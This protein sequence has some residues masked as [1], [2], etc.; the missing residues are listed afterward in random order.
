MRKKALSWLLSF[1]MV[2][3]LLTAIPITANAQPPE[4]NCQ[5]VETGIEYSNLDAALTA[6]LDGQ[7]IQLLTDIVYGSI[8]QTNLKGF[9]LDVNDH[10]LTVNSGFDTCVYTQGYDINII[11]NGPIDGVGAFYASS[12]GTGIMGLGASGYGTE[13]NIEV[14]ASIIV[15]GDSCKGI[16]AIEGAAIYLN[17]DVT[18]TGVGAVGAYADSGVY[19][20]L[21]TIDGEIT[22]T[23]YIQVNETTFSGPEQCILP[24]TKT[25]YL[26]YKWLGDSA[27]PQSTVWVKEESYVCEVDGVA[28]TTLDDGLVA[29]AVDWD[30]ITLLAD[31]NY[32]GTLAPNFDLYIDLNEHTLNVVNAS[33]IALRA[34]GRDI[35]ISGDGELNVNGTNYGIYACDGGSAVVTSATATAT[36]GTAVYVGDSS[37]SVTVRGD[38]T[39]LGENGVAVYTNDNAPCTATIQG[40]VYAQNTGGIGAKALSGSQ[41]TVMGR[42]YAETYIVTGSTVKTAGDYSSIDNNYYVF[43][44]GVS[45]VR[46]RQEVCAID[47]TPYLFLEDALADADGGDTITLLANIRF[48]NEI[49]LVDKDLHIDLDTY[50][51][52]VGRTN[53]D[54]A[55]T[56][57]GGMLTIDDTDGGE[58]NIVDGYIGVRVLNDATATVTSISG[59]NGYGIVGEIG[60]SVRV[61]EDISVLSYMG[62]GL[63]L[64]GGAT[65]HVMGDI[66]SLNGISVS[67]QGSAVVIDGDVSA[68]SGNGIEADSG[69]TVTVKG[70]VNGVYRGITA[71][72]WTAGGG[73]VHV[74]GSVTGNN[75][76]GVQASAASQVVV[77]GNVLSLKG[78]AAYNAGTCVT[79]GGDTTSTGAGE[80]GATAATGGLIT[81]NGE[82]SAANFALVGDTVMT[83]AEGVLDGRYNVYSDGVSSVRLKGIEFFK[84]DF[85][86][87][88]M[89]GWAQSD[90]GWSVTNSLTN[91]DTAAHSGSWAA[92]F[93]SLSLGSGTTSLLYQTEPLN[94]SKGTDYWLEF[95]MYHDSNWNG[96][97]DQVIVQISLDGGDWINLGTFH[98]LSAPLGW[99]K[100]AIDL[101]AYAGQP[102]VRIAFMGVS[103]YGYN[104]F[105]DDVSVSHECIIDGCSVTEAYGGYIGSSVIEGETYYHVET[106]E[107]LAHINDHMGLNFIQTAD[108]DLA[109]YNGG[110]WVP[111]GGYGDPENYCTPEEFT[112]KYLGDGHC[113]DN[114]Y[115]FY[116]GT[117]NA[118]HAGV[119]AALQGTAAFVDNLTVRVL[120]INMT[121]YN[122]AYFGGIAAIM[123]GGLIQNCHVVFEGD[124]VTHTPNGYAGGIVGSAYPDYDEESD[125]YQ[126][127][128]ENCE[129]TF[130]TGS[131]LT[132]GWSKYAGGI[133]GRSAVSI[134]GCNVVVGAGEMIKAP[135]VGGIVGSADKM[136]PLGAYLENCTVTGDGTLELFSQ[137]QYSAAIGGI[138]GSAWDGDLR[139]CDNEVAVI[140]DI[141]MINDGESIF[142]GG[143]VGHVGPNTTLLSCDN[144]GDV[145]LTIADNVVDYNGVTVTPV[146]DEYAYAGGITGFVNGYTRE[147]VIENCQNN[148]N[149]K[150][151]NLIPTN[152][153]YAGGIVGHID[154]DDGENAG[155]IVKNCANIGGDKK[156]ETYAGSTLTGGIAGSSTYNDFDTP[157]I[158]IENCYNVSEVYT[159][160]NSVPKTGTMCI[161]LTA[162]GIIGAAGQITVTACYSTAHDVNAVNNHEG[163]AYFGGIVG[164]IYNTAL[165]QNYYETNTFVTKAAGGIVSGMDI[166]AQSDVAGSYQGATAQNLKTKSFFGSAW[167]WYTS[168]GTAPDYYSSS[169]PWRMTSAT[170]YPA[171]RGAAYTTST[172]PTGGGSSTVTYTVTAT[173]G[174]GGAIS[175]SGSVSVVKLASQTFTITPNA[176]YKVSDVQVDG[177]SVGAVSVY[178]FSA[179][180]ANH[181]IKATFKPVRLSEKFAD[182]DPALWYADG[183]EFV[184][185]RGLFKGITDTTFEPGAPM[186]RGMLVT[187]LHR[188]HGN[189]AVSIASL[190]ADVDAGSWYADAV[191]WANGSGVVKGYDE[192]TFGPN[193]KLTREQ[194][195]VILFRYASFSGYDT[196]ARADLAAYSDAN[197]VSSWAVEAMQWAVAKGLITGTSE[198]T[199]DASGFAGRAQVATILM[200]FVQTFEK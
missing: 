2:L 192:K 198:A 23:N 16:Y 193:D 148:A 104:M 101:S 95:W 194:L 117:Q 62:I 118:T 47:G 181:T 34:D 89:E 69:G 177:A 88:T 40:D 22:A 149:I 105:I 138:A 156:V 80:Y 178:T 74:F 61:K 30:T 162:G 145:T 91:P 108:I 9:T 161:G 68:S 109:D 8:L 73:N 122:Y 65:A 26:T 55:L 78:L 200:R 50:S 190:F 15:P 41:I 7:T 143:I 119:F 43:S 17:G 174:T 169:T 155:V 171:L 37:C 159:E 103:A 129:V 179:V 97:D 86:D 130:D 134:L 173:A 123:D 135:M 137:D 106:P 189:P 83:E 90:T 32:A 195:A 199:L 124:I 166:V 188:L 110:I 146:G 20:S 144:T 126:G 18:A 39:A 72:G 54:G 60:G 29:A 36:G 139:S 96:N 182:V 85:E 71:Y 10:V 112:G 25:G 45:S 113:I 153:A 125:S 42:I 111:I 67:G 98:R 102:D 46:A 5:I 151:T 70:D 63:T 131:I 191:G 79:V 99:R 186:T 154:C 158:L 133:A 66:I 53:S 163:D 48:E 84:E 12:T 24:T 107:Q 184:L 27:N 58:L 180:T 6:A 168:G 176:G 1:S 121:N 57:D 92:K 114:L 81:V 185:G 100:E 175:P 132:D 172:P 93:N 116:D 167:K 164:L 196:T 3:S 157:N 19:G 140:A 59:L 160:S 127:S 52:D 31:I 183:I 44:D 14:P 76:Y 77:D 38:A 197:G 94:L 56:V 21:V 115:C 150:A 170:S 142:A 120:G 87:G 75:D 13:I 11:D 147:S 33:G 136:K 35:G 51:L 28:Y 128:I 152:R 141:S 187:V 49:V 82:V 4:F 64:Y 165:S